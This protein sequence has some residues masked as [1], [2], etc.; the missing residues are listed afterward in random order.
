MEQLCS[1]LCLLP[2]QPA[3]LARVRMRYINISDDNCYNYSGCGKKNK[4][5][6]RI[7][8]LVAE[9]LVCSGCLMILCWGCVT[10][11]KSEPPSCQFIIFNLN[12]FISALSHTHTRKHTLFLSFL[13]SVLFSFEWETP[14]YT[15]LLFFWGGGFGWPFPALPLTYLLPCSAGLS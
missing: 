10:K 13:C 15:F 4:Q 9:S 7:S 11:N 2:S 6:T 3:A 12:L 14:N 5:Q 1:Y 8:C